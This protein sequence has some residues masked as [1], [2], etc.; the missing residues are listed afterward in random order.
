MFQTLWDFSWKYIFFLEIHLNWHLYYAESSNLRTQCL[1]VFWADFFS[2]YFVT[3]MF[4]HF[5]LQELFFFFKKTVS[6]SNCSDWACR[7]DWFCC[8]NDISQDITKCTY[9]FWVLSVDH[10]GFPTW[11][12]VP[13]TD[14]DNWIPTLLAFIVLNRND[15]SGAFPSVVDLKHCLS[16]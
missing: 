13:L 5:T 2:R 16:Q 7:N 12:V 10:F 3:V 6:V 4:E 9:S 11:I 1:C 15:G 8:A 14:Q